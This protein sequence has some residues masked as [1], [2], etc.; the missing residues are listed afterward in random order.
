MRKVGIEFQVSDHCN[1]G[2]AGCD[3][4]SPLAPALFSDLESIR[5]D[6]LRIKEIFGD[7][8]MDRVHI[9]GGEPLLN[10]EVVAYLKMCRDI[11]SKCRI[12]LVTNGIGLLQQND[13]FWK[14]CR[15]N[16]IILRPTKYPINVDYDEIE[17]K[18]H[19][20]SVH[21]RYYNE[22]QVIKK[23][24]RIKLDPHGK[25]NPHHSFEIC[26]MANRCWLLKNGKLY[27]CPII[28]NIEH[29]NKYFG[30]NFKVVKEDYVDIYDDVSAEEIIQNM[31]KCVP[32]CC[33]CNNDAKEYDLDW[34]RTEKSSLEWGVSIG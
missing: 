12:E 8:N 33:F 16:S 15:D 24:Y 26:N 31:G 29:F 14:V 34:K 19:C 3:H 23:Q 6:L 10:K 25:C 2:C 17:K 4:F 22:G 32:F 20:E 13:D 18:A 21:F 30:M 7:E 11:F 9:L 28:P 1:L 27:T 5:K